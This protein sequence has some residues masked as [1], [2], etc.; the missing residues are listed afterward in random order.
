MT[1]SANDNY[2]GGKWNRLKNQYNTTSWN[3][4]AWPGETD[5]HLFSWW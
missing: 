5:Q 1:P 3:P 2:W 4:T